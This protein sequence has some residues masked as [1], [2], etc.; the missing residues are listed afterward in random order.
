LAV[1]DESDLASDFLGELG[2]VAGELRGDDLLRGDL[3][4]VDALQALYL[5]RPQTVGI[6]VYFLNRSPR[7]GRVS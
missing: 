5:A 2:E 6:A 7:N 1:A 3:A 4:T